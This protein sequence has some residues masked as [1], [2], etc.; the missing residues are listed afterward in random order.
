MSSISL[1]ERNLKNRQNFIQM[2]Y[3]CALLLLAY[4]NITDSSVIMKKP[5][6]V[7]NLI[8]MLFTGII[9]VKLITQRY[10][11][12]KL[13]FSVCLFCLC[14]YTCIKCYYF[15][16]YFTALLFIGIQDVDLEKV[17]NIVWKFKAF[18]ISIHVIVY[19]INFLSNPY[20][21]PYSYRNG[22]QRMTFYQG[23]ANTFSMYICWISM[24]FLYSNFKKLTPLKLGVLWLINYVFYIFCDSNTALTIITFACFLIALTMLKNG[25]VK[26]YEFLLKIF[27]KYLYAF[28]SIFFVTIIIGFVNGYF[29]SIFETLN[30]LFT[31]R[32]LYGAV[33]Y[34]MK[35][36]SI[37]G[38]VVEFDSKVYWKGYWID[39]MIF[40]NCYIWMMV[41][42]GIV[43]LVL[44]S[45]AAIVFNSRMDVRDRI[46]I[47]LYTLY[48]IMEAYVMNAAICFPL[49][50]FGMY[51]TGRREPKLSAGINRL[52]KKGHVI[53]EN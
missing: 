49:L 36:L 45:L 15:Y 2:L 44:I 7:D 27:S 24:E 5:D 41:C 33:A 10:T 48:T 21:V 52:W 16:L 4:K 32:L 43:Y 8:I 46:F 42:Y 47:I 37:F 40:D 17:L 20:S 13:I 11:Y 35:G 9:G 38:K 51:F 14:V 26:Y 3:T 31:G 28:L 25:L 39:G 30:E 12:A 1:A 18:L 6:I 50:I 53:D 22:V 23:H 34:D 29:L 19:M